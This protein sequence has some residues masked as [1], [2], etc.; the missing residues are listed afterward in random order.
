MKLLSTALVPVHVHVH[1]LQI[2]TAM[3]LT[4]PIFVVE[5]HLLDLLLYL[6]CRSFLICRVFNFFDC[7]FLF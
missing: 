3:L 4:L 6:I 1:V 7:S 2:L 5:L